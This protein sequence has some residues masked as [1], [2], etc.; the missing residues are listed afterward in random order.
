MVF[1]RGAR[2]SSGSAAIGAPFGN[3][4]LR[5]PL[6]KEFDPFMSSASLVRRS[7]LLL[8]ALV[9]LG[10][11]LGAGST[12]R[13]RRA[14]Q[15]LTVNGLRAPLDLDEAPRFGWHVNHA[16]QSAYE[17]RV[18]STAL[19]AENAEADV[20]ATGVVRSALQ[21]E[22]AYT[23]P[24]LAPAQRYFWTLRTRDERGRWSAW[25]EVAAFG[26]GPGASWSL[27]QPIWAA[28]A[29]SGWA[30]YRLAT[31]LTI[32]EVALGIRFRAPDTRNGYMWQFRAADNRLVPHRLVDGAFS[33]IESVAF[34]RERSPWA[35]RQRW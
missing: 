34:P 24:A 17:L 15:A 13:D 28:S 30:D 33:V 26:T 35:A 18:A 22:V 16:E 20:W 3:T 8:A 4:P 23:G 31:R 11:S 9:A 7:S 1:A 12:A 27:S 29:A 6:P 32:D 25:S 14:P 2:W 5:C 19:A 10:S 21:N